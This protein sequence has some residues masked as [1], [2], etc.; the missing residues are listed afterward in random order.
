MRMEKVVTN[1]NVRDDGF[2]VNNTET[3]RELIHIPADGNHVEILGHKLEGDFKSFKGFCE[4]LRKVDRTE[5]NWNNLKEWLVDEIDK[6]ENDKWVSF[7]EVVRAGAMKKLYEKM[8]E[9][10]NGR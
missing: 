8:E 2:C 6:Y 5:S 4:Y 1:V 3:A 10:E 9:L 7:Q